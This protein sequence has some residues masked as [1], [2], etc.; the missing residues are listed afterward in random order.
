MR[1]FVI[2][3]LIICLFDEFICVKKKLSYFMELFR[4]LISI[5]LNSVIYFGLSSL[6]QSLIYHLILVSIINFMLFI[7][8]PNFINNIFTSHQKV[9]FLTYSISYAIFFYYLFLNYFTNINLLYFFLFS[10]MLFLIYLF[11]C[12]IN[13]DF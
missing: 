12:L 5:L 2:K 8:I 10:L 6:L 9:F 4:F 11:I 13:V 1:I 7:D 3:S